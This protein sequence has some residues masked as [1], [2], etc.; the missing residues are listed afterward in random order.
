M[1]QRPLANAGAFLHQPSTI[2]PSP[3]TLYTAPMPFVIVSGL[4]GSGK[5]TALRTLEDAGFF[6]TDNLPP[7]LWGAMHDLVSARGIENVAVS[8]DTR[9]REFL[10]ALD[11]S[12]VRLSRRHENLRVIFLEANAEVLLGRYNLSRREHPLGE[13]LMVDFARERE[14]L[15][16]LRAIADTVIDTTSL[17]AAQLSERIMRLFRLEHAF[18]LRLLSFGFKH[19]PPRDADLVLDVRSLPNP[20]YDPALRPL[21]GRQ[22]D[23]A[24]YVFRDPEAEAFYAEVRHF[25]QTA[26]ER[27]RASGRHS[28]TVGIGCTGGQH[29]SVA[30]AERLLHELR[31][32][33]LDTDL[34]DH[35]DMKEGGESA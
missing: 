6:I 3:F 21:S 4:S 5:S 22:P 29:R 27:A 11:S 28:Y 26:A 1:K 15:A 16:P 20:Y 33:G 17:S 25:V 30:V 31:E 12:Y 19:A 14:L 24:A 34:M 32:S 2:L 10:A 8:T 23:V 7:E 35:R 18:T 9:T 13:T